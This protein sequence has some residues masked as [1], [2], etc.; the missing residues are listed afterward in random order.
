MALGF[1]FNKQ[2]ILAQ[3]EK[4]VQ[5]GKLQNA[6]AEYEKVVKEDPKDLTV[7]GLIGDFHARVGANDKASYYFKRVG[8]IY[9]TEGFTVKAIAVYKKITKL[10]PNNTE[11]ITRLA[12]LYTQQGLYNDARQQYVA[13]ADHCMKANQLEEAARIF[14]KILEL[15][16]ENTAMQSKLADLYI[17]LGRKE[18]ARNIFL[19]A[20]QSL[21]NRGALDAADEALK[22]VI[23]LD[24]HNQEAALLRGR[25][26]SDSGDSTTAIASLN[27][28]PDLDSRPEALRSL[29]IAH[30]QAGKYDE[31]EPLARKLL[32]VHNDPS[33]LA[34]LADTLMKA[35]E[36]ESALKIYNQYSDRFLAS[37]AAALVE[38]L[39][40]SISRIKENATA[41]ELARG[42][43][44]KANAHAHI[45]EVSELLAHAW[46]QSGE[47][48]KAAEIYKELSQLEPENPLHLQNYKQIQGKLGK[49]P[50]VREM[51]KEDGA[52]ALMV[53][54]LELE[55]PPLETHYLDSV[56]EAVKAAVTEAELFESYNMPHKALG[57]LESALQKAPRDSQLNQK[58]A[59]LYARSGRMEE[60]IRCCTVLRDIYTE[61]G[62]DREARRFGEMAE[63][64]RGRSKAASAAASVEFDASFMPGGEIHTPPPTSAPA[65]TAGTSALSGAGIPASAASTGSVAEFNI[66]PE[67]AA[68]AQN[69]PGNIAEFA[70]DVASGHSQ[71]I[72]QSALE[73][74]SQTGSSVSAPPPS[75]REI[76]L[77]E[78]ESMTSVEEPA[79]PAAAQADTG[80]LIEEIRF[81]LSQSMWEE[82]RSGIEKLESQAPAAPEIADLRQ[83]LQAGLA[84]AERAKAEA[85]AEKARAS[86]AEQKAKAEAAA[87]AEKAKAT[88]SKA[89]PKKEKAEEPPAKVAAQPAAVTPEDVKP[90][91]SKTP[92]AKAPAA[93][94][95]AKKTTG[96]SDFVLDLDESLGEDF[97]FGGKP[98]AS[99]P[100][101]SAP[102]GGASSPSMSAAQSKA[103]PSSFRPLAQAGAAS[104]ANPEASS[105]LSDMFAE[106]KEDVEEGSD[107][108]EDPDTHYNLGVA[109][110]EMGLLDE[111]IGELQKVCKAIDRGSPFSQVMQAYTWLAHCFLEKGTPEASVKW[112]ERALKYASGDE[113]SK[114]AVYYEL[115]SAH[116]AAGNKKA[117]L[118]NFMEVYGSNIDYRDVADRIK[119]LKSQE[120]VAVSGGDGPRA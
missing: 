66:T 12:E 42:I 2:K 57:P 21:Y 16:S 24:P 106:F 47:L 50:T 108:S 10:N 62:H 23:S 120:S 61:A 77:S 34:T 90:A 43:L 5:Q 117:A 19:T 46:V 28:V 56:N 45:N 22:K 48:Q 70:I 49:D 82:S 112:Y 39:A 114:L 95:A 72:S 101:T 36:V 53:D 32:S 68:N 11:C 44:V 115:G 38:T 105:A 97:A 18:D 71:A 110:K 100:P 83:Q 54:E 59:V 63:K 86:A 1:G 17:K 25:I 96:L 98:A 78:W 74:A 41:L 113:E 104:F 4:F 27:K 9:A 93:K 8:D 15:D 76:D 119:V 111:A 20:A 60:A 92:P 37:G 7:L 91:A 75:A 29:M 51:S 85:A 6:I 69:A 55:S 88:A 99:A 64:Y 94:P 73:Q 118:A 67:I 33:G 107:D 81:F 14:Q 40:G 3:A 52:Q 79:P 102:A 13:V 103:E 80:P 26:A 109:F 35:G 89:A 65:A 31:G 116:E 87:A 84:A 58:L 30:L